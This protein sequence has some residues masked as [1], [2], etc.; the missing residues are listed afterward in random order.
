MKVWPARV[1]LTIDRGETAKTV[2]RVG[3]E[4]DK[5]IRVHVYAMDFCAD[6]KHGL[7]LSEP[8][9]ESFSC[10][11]W[12][13]LD[14]TDFELA[15][16]ESKEVKVAISVPP[17]VEPGGHHAALLFE[18]VSL[19]VETAFSVTISARIASLFYL[20]IPGVT[21]ADVF[22]S[23]EIVSL[24]M[25]GLAAGGPVEV[26]VIVRNT[27]NVHLEVAATAYF[28]GL[29]G[30][31]VGELDLGQVVILRQSE[32]VIEANWEKTPFLD[33]VKAKVVIGYFDEH[34]E[35][36]NEDATASFW[37]TPQ[38]KIVIAAAAS[39]AALLVLAWLSRRRYRLRLER[40]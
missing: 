31:N 5:P 37:V 21:D 32:R 16:G 3:N 24:T 38:R 4:G 1:E 30:R 6:K 27:G 2:V 28:Y 34:G 22:A 11:A 13:D 36:V 40:R 12:L 35:L 29:W 7:S 25:P 8:G 26:G 17:E 20:T 10:S 39:L 9:H 14:Q 33:K 15:P 23:A 18:T 19:K